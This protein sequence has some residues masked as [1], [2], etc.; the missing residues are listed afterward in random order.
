MLCTR[1]TEDML[2]QISMPCHMAYIS[3]A[4]RRLS[5]DEARRRLSPK[6]TIYIIDN[7]KKAVTLQLL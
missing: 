4:E 3:L 1:L 5:V 7:G 2:G 6:K